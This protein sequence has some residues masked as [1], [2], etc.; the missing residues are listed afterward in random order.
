MQILYLSDNSSQQEIIRAVRELAEAV[1]LLEA[2]IKD[3]TSGWADSQS[4]VTITRGYDANATST[5]ELADVLGT[6][7][8]DLIDVGLI[9]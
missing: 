3:N 7:I 8:V 1:R 4:N 6:L 9:K 5:A 2:R